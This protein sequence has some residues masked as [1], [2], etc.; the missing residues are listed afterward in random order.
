VRP[1]FPLIIIIP[2]IEI[3]LLF[4]SGKYIGFLPTLLIVIATGMIGFR[5]AKS[6]GTSILIKIKADM[7]YG[8]MPG[9]SVLEGFLVLLGGI[10]LIFPGYLTDLAGFLLMI[11]FV[12]K[13]FVNILR[14]WIMKQFQKG[15]FSFTFRR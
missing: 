4:L 8:R 10:F 12:R 13:R 11:P 2:I 3:Y 15:N 14:K 6:Q 9:D 1:W 5:L 7:S